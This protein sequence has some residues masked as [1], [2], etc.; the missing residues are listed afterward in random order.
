M[1]PTSEMILVKSYSL[2]ASQFSHLQN[3]V[4]M[5][6]I[7]MVCAEYVEQYWMHGHG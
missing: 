1:L 7:E 4:A 2:S 6:L 5:S 3:Q